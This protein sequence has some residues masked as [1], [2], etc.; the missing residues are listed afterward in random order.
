[1][2]RARK[3]PGQGVKEVPAE[4]G[5]SLSSVLSLFH[6]PVRDWFEEV[7]A[8]P[9]RPQLLGWPAIAR[10]ESTLILAPTGSG[11]TLAAFLWC[12]D[13]LCFLRRLS[14]TAVAWFTFPR[15]RL[16]QLTLS[17]T[18]SRPLWELHRRRVDW[19]FRSTN[20]P[21][22]FAREIRHD[23]N[24]R[25]LSRHPADILITTPESTLSFADLRCPGSAALRG[26][27][28]RRRNP[29]DSTDETRIASGAV[30]GTIGTNCGRSCNGLDFQRHSARWKK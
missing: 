17:A 22:R 2:A 16:W 25:S 30:T 14:G 29:R 8:A 5:S 6:K 3:K 21:W 27:G 28:Y 20:P 15:S 18:C 23:W 10:G 13:R 19:R 1:M 11:K 9:T 24:A 7:F 4:N 26:S 12:I